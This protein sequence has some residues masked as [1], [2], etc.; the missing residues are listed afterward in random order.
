MDPTK[1][2][3]ILDLKPPTSIRQL[4]ETLGHTCYYKS[5]I[6]GYAQITSPMEK[7]LK[8][9]DKFQWNDDCQK[10]LDTLNKKIVTALILIFLEWKTEFHVH[11]DASS[12]DLGVVLSHLGKGDID[13][14]ITFARKKLSTEE[15]NYTTTE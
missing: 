9:E 11:V 3:L 2:A 13:H 4:R 14:P 8:K 7:L 12:I 15:N 6:K 1:V 5:F 10:G